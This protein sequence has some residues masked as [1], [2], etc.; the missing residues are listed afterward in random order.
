MNR[1]SAKFQ[2]KLD[3]IN[4]AMKNIKLPE[5]IQ[6]KV[7]DYITSTQSTLDH[8]QEMEVFMKL[9]SPTLR[10]EVTRHIFSVVVRDNPIFA[11]EQYD[12]IIQ[13]LWPQLY[14]PENV[15]I[16]QSDFSERMYFLEHIKFIIYWKSY[17]E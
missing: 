13:F 4:S 9:I 2:N 17:I 5:L 15:I 16:Y 8:Q 12:F 10:L 14:W 1:K 6:H 7:Q 3:S 11:W